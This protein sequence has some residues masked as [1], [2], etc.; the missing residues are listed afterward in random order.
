MGFASVWYSSGRGGILAT[1]GGVRVPSPWSYPS[2]LAPASGLDR[3][4]V[5][6]PHRHHGF[7]GP[8]RGGAIRI[9][10][11]LEQDAR[12]DLPGEAPAVLA[13]AASALLAAV[14][15]DRV[16]V[17]VGLFLVLG[18]DHETDRLVRLEIRP[19]IQA[20]VG[21]PKDGELDG[22]ILAHLRR[23]DLHGGGVSFP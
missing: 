23:R 7:H 5:D 22:E 12:R 19:S 4:D 16:P 14:A 3:G 13:P 15:D 17:T 11:R 21:L 1:R 20:D 10:R 2:A 8:L 9:G 18:Q 6:L